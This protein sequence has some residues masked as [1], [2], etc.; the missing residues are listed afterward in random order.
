MQRYI[1]FQPHS[2][3][4]DAIRI[5]LGYNNTIEEMECMYQAIKQILKD[6]A[7]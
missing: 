5:S 1:S 7:Y 3:A 4:L 2:S 6:E